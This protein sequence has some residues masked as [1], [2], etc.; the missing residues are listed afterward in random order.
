MSF[1]LYELTHQY[2]E[3]LDHITESEVEHPGFAD[4]LES[5]EDAIE[6]KLNSTAIIIKTLESQAKALKDEENRMKKRRQSFENN[7]DR[8]K[9]YARQALEATGKDKIKGNNFTLRMQNNP[10]SANILDNKVIPGHYLI[11]Q[12]PAIDKKGLL[13]DLKNGIAVEGAELKQG[14]SLRIV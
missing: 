2:Q 8:L 1:R 14:R 6:D 7:I 13:E 11:E 5:I 10:P 4:T 3:L 9:D 12:E